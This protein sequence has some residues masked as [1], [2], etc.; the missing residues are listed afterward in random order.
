MNTYPTNLIELGSCK[1]GM[2]L[3]NHR[4]GL[5]AILLC[6]ECGEARAH[7]VRIDAMFAMACIQLAG[8]LRP[9]NMTVYRVR[10]CNPDKVVGMCISG[11]IGLQ[12]MIN[13]PAPYRSHECTMGHEWD[14]PVEWDKTFNLTG[15]ATQY[16]PEC[17]GRSEFAS[18]WK[19]RGSDPTPAP[20]PE[21]CVLGN[22][23]MRKLLVRA[24]PWL[25]S[26][27]AVAQRPEDDEELDALISSIYSHAPMGSQTTP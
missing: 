3:W 5:P 12:F 20:V 4:D 11:D 23:S 22:D 9:E 24:L 26:A 19:F 17:G 18:A 6:G 21:P 7:S 14:A 13:L 10:F 2:P 16:C 25:E 27:H 1:P 8:V 15:E